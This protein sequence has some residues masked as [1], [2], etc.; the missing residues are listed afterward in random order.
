MIQNL[1]DWLYHWADWTRRHKS[2]ALGYPRQTIE[3]ELYRMGGVLIKGEGGPPR[4]TMDEDV[5]EAHDA[6]QEL[7][8]VKLDHWH[9]I[10]TH[11]YDPRGL[12]DRAKAGLAGVWLGRPISESV[13][14]RM[15]RE[16]RIWLEAWRAGRKSRVSA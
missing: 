15:L 3:H 10:R 12:T 2:E 5:S 16:A 13:Y 4:I 8:R 7:A 14:K 11:Y 9:V 6:L 1:D